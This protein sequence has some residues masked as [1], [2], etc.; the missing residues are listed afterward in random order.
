MQKIEKISVL[1]ILE[2]FKNLPKNQKIENFNFYEN[3]DFFRTAN[4]FSEGGLLGAIYNELTTI[5]QKLN[6]YFQTVKTE[7]SQYK[8]NPK[9]H[10]NQLLQEPVLLSKSISVMSMVAD[11][12]DKFVQTDKEFS[13]SDLFLDIAE[14]P[15]CPYLIN[16][17]NSNTT[18]IACKSENSF[19]AIQ[20]GKALCI[21]EDGK[22]IYSQKGAH[23][24]LKI[25]KLRI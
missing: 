22:S 19:G 1:R 6:Q 24:K 10:L 20:Y 14:K 23:S 7:I 13:L 8:R 3:D 18:K 16:N 4:S 5:E 9:S 21:I 15:I 11:K 25:Q 2:K 17:G 12:K